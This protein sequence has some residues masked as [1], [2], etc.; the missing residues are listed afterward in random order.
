MPSAQSPSPPPTAPTA[1]TPGVR[2][3]AFQTIYD[4]TLTSTLN[5]ISYSSFASCF[6]S[7]A[8]AAPD[9]LRSLHTNF[10]QRLRDFA[11]VQQPAPQ[12]PSATWF[13][14]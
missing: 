12:T 1:L 11:S 5:S 2:A 9:S 10:I 3:A 7:I 8:A 13:A 6:P 14:G 4:K